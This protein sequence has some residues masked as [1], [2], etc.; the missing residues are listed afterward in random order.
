MCIEIFYIDKKITLKRNENSH[1]NISLLKEKI[2]DF[3]LD[4]EKVEMEIF[5]D[6]SD[7]LLLH[8]KSF[9]K[10]I[11]AAGGVV[12]DKEHKNILLL[13]RLGKCDLPKGKIEKNE[14]PE[15]SAI[16]EV[17]E[18]CGIYGQ[19]I[20]KE[21]QPTYH[22]YILNEK[23]YLKKTYW[24]EMEYYG[25]EKPTPQITENI[26]KVYWNKIC[27]LEQCLA[28]TYSNLYSIFDNYQRIL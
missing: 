12:F 9:F 10:Y 8:I 22:I 24:F 1:E 13:E 3:L 6:N 25:N 15:E 27:D 14:K 17:S 20:L 23:Y 4:K 7:E 2:F 26:S 16:R 28:N 5:S 18:E 11:E 19:R 21:I